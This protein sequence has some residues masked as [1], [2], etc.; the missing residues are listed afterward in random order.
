M[1]FDEVMAEWNRLFCGPEIVQSDCPPDIDEVKRQFLEFF[2]AHHASMSADCRERAENM[3]VTGF[4]TLEILEQHLPDN[5]S[6]YGFRAVLDGL[7]GRPT[8]APEAGAFP[9]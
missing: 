3:F 7:R 1:E 4:A 2:T 5:L 8:P 9:P 6:R